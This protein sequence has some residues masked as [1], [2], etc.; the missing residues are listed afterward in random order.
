MCVCVCVC[1][2]V[3]GRGG[4]IVDSGGHIYDM[5]MYSYQKNLGGKTLE[6]S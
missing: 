4:N 2:C 1:V 6:S 5:Y 3:S